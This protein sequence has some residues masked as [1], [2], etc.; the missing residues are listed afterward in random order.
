M[1]EM[2]CP[3]YST[4]G[5]AAG[6]SR[7]ID[8]N[9]TESHPMSESPSTESPSTES[10]RSSGMSRAARFRRRLM[11]VAGY[12]VQLVGQPL[13]A[14]AAI[15]GLVYG[16]GVAQQRGYFTSADAAPQDEAATADVEYFCPMMC[17]PPVKAPGRCP[18]CNMELQAREISGDTKDFYGLTISPAARRLSNIRTV[19][20]VTKPL[21][22]Q[23][24]ALG[25]ISYDE[26]TEATIPA[27]IDGRLDE[28]FV[29]YTGAEVAQGEA[30]ALLYS[31][32]LY[33]AQAGLLEAAKSLRSGD[34]V[35]S[36][37][38]E[39]SRKLYESARRRLLEFGVPEK[40]VNEIEASGR[41]D[42]RI[43]IVSPISG[44]VVEKLADE[45][46]YVKMGTPLLRVVDLSRVWLMLEIFP[47]DARLLRYGQLIDVALQ[48]L[49]GRLFEGRV[50]FV[51]PIVDP[52]TQT[53][54]VRV[55]IPNESGLIRIGDYARATVSVEVHA[56]GRV[57]DEVYDPRLAGKWISPRHP[58]IIRDQPGPCPECGA[59][60]VPA[61]QF[62]FVTEPPEQQG[63]VV[64]PRQAILLSGEAS[65]AY[66]ETDPG[67]FEFRKVQIG[68]VSGD[69]VAVVSGIKAGESIVA[70]ATFMVDAEFN[71]ASKPS[72][73]DPD[74]TRPVDESAKQPRPEVPEEIRKALSQLEPRERALAEAQVVCPVTG[75]DL[76]SMGPPVKVEVAGRQVMI[77]CEGC[78]KG[79]LAE[80]EKHLA[81]LV[82]YQA[83]GGTGPGSPEDLEVEQALAELSAE[84]R[85]LAEAQGY[86]PVADFRLGGM[87][88]PLK[89]DVN[90]TP[91]F[92][93][94][95]G[96]RAELLA[97]PEVHLARVEQ[98]RNNGGR[99]LS[100]KQPD[101]LQP[102]SPLPRM[103][104]PQ[105][106]LPQMELPQKE[107]PQMDPPQ[108]K[109]GDRELP[110]LEPPDL[111]GS[112]GQPVP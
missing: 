7:A 70:N 41:A 94:C 57:R 85:A 55:V 68:P 46:D 76:G 27:W 25:T 83:A 49:P 104:L 90:G 1:A 12:W 22:K 54:S 69:E 20:A 95:E 28:L 63:G 5:Y 71:I 99:N 87:G 73:M 56:D 80:P 77:C 98:Y 19:T 17:V 15:V 67:R 40:Q 36:R 29:D 107:L 38:Q 39:T 23:I 66:V 110:R 34:A 8:L 44:T 75:L 111:S 88:T 32:E 53:L 59:D 43:R 109:A 14:I 102:S 78:R 108:Q 33:A 26:T 60:L 89:V 47:E 21:V 9:V 82:R 97:N 51:D 10:G 100:A 61:E 112:R 50:A 52:S 24:H 103:D 18:V 65:V 35:S 3:W 42:S 13:V 72:I 16:L 64:V 96:C 31:P 4:G 74:R 91:V 93:C 6:L 81:T 79:L 11:R 106:E 45:G 30:L 2:P 105:M 86:C 92:I 58:W 37:L 101:Q 84:D 62:G 48:S